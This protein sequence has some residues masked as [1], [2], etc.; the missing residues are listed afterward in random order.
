M[1][2]YIC[3]LFNFSDY[4]I[5]H[6]VY[7]YKNNLNYFPKIA[8][9][10]VVYFLNSL[11]ACNVRA[12]P[13]EISTYRLLRQEVWGGSRQQNSYQKGDSLKKVWESLVDACIVYHVFELNYLNCKL[14]HN[15]KVSFTVMKIVTQHSKNSFLIA[16]KTS[17]I[18]KQL[19][20]QIK[21]LNIWSLN[22]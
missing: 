13:V 5:L 12:K 3:T 8:R 15:Y 18:H 20:D 9:L 14:P 21:K 1:D 16:V 17:D 11:G 2:K 7:T 6:R 19:S 4:P 10:N 22:C